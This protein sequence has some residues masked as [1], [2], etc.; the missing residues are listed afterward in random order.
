MLRPEA[1]DGFRQAI[2]AAYEREFGVTPS[3]YSCKPSAGAGEVKA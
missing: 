3:I 1:A 2:T